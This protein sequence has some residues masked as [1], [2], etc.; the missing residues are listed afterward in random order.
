[1]CVCVCVC[2][3]DCVCVRVGQGWG[4]GGTHDRTCDVCKVKPRICANKKVWLTIFN[5]GRPLASR[6]VQVLPSMLFCE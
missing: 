6:M 1:M 3:C 4:G 5:V 2:V